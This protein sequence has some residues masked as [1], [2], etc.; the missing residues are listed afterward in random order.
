MR[1]LNLLKYLI[2]VSLL[3]GCTD[4]QPIQVNTWRIDMGLGLEKPIRA[5][6]ITD[7]HYREGQA[8]FDELLQI[9]KDTQPDL[10]LLGGDYTGM[11]ARDTDR[12]RGFMVDELSKLSQEA[13]TYAV[14]GN[15]EDYSNPYQW[16]QALVRSPVRFSEGHV[17][18]LSIRGINVCVRGLG[19]AY[20]GNY[21]HVPF[22]PD[23]TELK[24][25]LTHDPYAVQSDPE[26][27]LYLAGH[28]HGGGQIIL[29]L[30][31]APWTPTEA[32][33]DYWCG[34]GRDG[35]KQW[36]T[37]SGVGTTFIDVRIGTTSSV[38]LVE[39]Y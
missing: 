12:L 2:L 9:A 19:D 35:D 3:S 32:S 23:C 16:I 17:D 26:T 24:L 4:D 36:T 14:L 8:V 15:H 6:H 29:P 27:G 11:G 34:Y 22:N 39:M 21:L 10:I 38:E 20:T 1:L 30:I 33:Q 18:M 37:S 5:L 25:T 7:I 31:G 13:P 28:L